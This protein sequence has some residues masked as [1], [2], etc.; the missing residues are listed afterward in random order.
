MPK[1]SISVA[2]VNPE[3]VDEV[4][5]IIARSQASRVALEAAY[6]K[7]ADDLA[8]LIERLHAAAAPYI[9]ADIERRHQVNPLE[10][11]REALAQ[12]VT[13]AVVKKSL[14]PRYESQEREC[15]TCG[16]IALCD[17][18]D[19]FDVDNPNVICGPCSA[20]ERARP[21]APLAD[22]QEEEVA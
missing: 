22:L 14:M 9:T 19:I 18:E 11:L 13:D 3:V 5:E 8:Q 17:Y 12:A 7:M 21:Y 16:Q 6:K 4:D 1:Y 15:D 10:P 20:T 2:P